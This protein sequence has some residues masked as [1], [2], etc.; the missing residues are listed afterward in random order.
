VFVN[1]VLRR[2]FG[3]RR[4]VIWAWGKLHNRA[5]HNFK[6]SQS[7]LRMTSEAGEMG[8]ACSTNE[9]R[10]GI[11]ISYWWVGQKERDHWEDQGV[12]AYNIEMDARVRELGGM[13][14]I[15]LAQDRDRWKAVLIT[16]MNFRVP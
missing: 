2:I 3:P 1:R 7:I 12:W 15:D 5:R 9:G 10:P 8:W 6:F 11:H 13:D 4:E 14:W 16:V